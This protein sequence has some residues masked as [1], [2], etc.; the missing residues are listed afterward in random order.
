MGRPAV[1]A[2][3][4]RNARA[5]PP[6]KRA[7]RPSRRQ[8]RRVTPAQFVHAGMVFLHSILEDKL[9][10]VH[11]RPQQVFDGLSSLAALE[12]LL[13]DASLGIRRITTVG[14]EIELLD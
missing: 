1:A 9:R 5:R 10:R 14:G 13:G 6:P 4:T 3:R 8:S 7:P 2:A 12:R 11:Q